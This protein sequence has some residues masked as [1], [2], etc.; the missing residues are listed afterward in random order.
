[1]LNNNQYSQ[2]KNTAENLLKAKNYNQTG[3]IWTMKNNG[4]NWKKGLIISGL[5]LIPGMAQAAENPY[6][7]GSLKAS[8]YI[9]PFTAIADQILDPPAAGDKSD[10]LYWYDND[11]NCIEN[12]PGACG[13]NKDTNNNTPNID[14]CEKSPLLKGHIY[15][16]VYGQ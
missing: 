1:M 9:N 4:G 12:I 5:L 6:I 10:M 14:S 8:N 13:G 15:K 16:N 2:Q 11:G 7:E 3:S